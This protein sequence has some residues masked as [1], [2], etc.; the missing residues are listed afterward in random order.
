MPEICHSCGSNANTELAVYQTL[1]RVS[2]DCKPVPA[3]GQLLSCNECGAIS[4][5]ATSEFLADIGRIYA[6]YDVYYQGGGMEQIV[7]DRQSGQP[8][9]RSTLLADRLTT[10][11]PMK[12][13]GRAIDIGCGNGVFLSALSQRL[14]GWQFFGLELDD[15]WLPQLQKIPGFKD[16]IVADVMAF[17]GTFDVISMIHALEHFTD[18]VAVLK[19]IRTRLSDDGLLF[20]EIPNV[21]EN[22]FDLLIADHVTHNTPAS[23]SRMLRKAGFA[24]QIL[25]TNWVSKEMSIVATPASGTPTH[26]HD[27][28]STANDKTLAAR[29][30][31][32]LAACLDSARRASEHKPFGLFGTS[33]AATWLA[34]DLKDRIDFFVDEDESRQ[35]GNFFGHPII[36]PAK[37]ADGAT[38]F[39][40]LAPAI[41]SVVSARLDQNKVTVLL[42][43]NT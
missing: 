16:L 33:I 25:E 24:I 32:W 27:D 30:L 38:V 18:P 23:L 43:D 40:G 11:F 9:R 22:P 42:P 41:A 6:D 15:R 34:G 21:A 13:H 26:D 19:S 7:F 36:A 2:S 29:H 8:M 20:I 28:A 4:K 12:K 31:D 3:G 14:K 5:P 17:E 10:A 1:P 39:V 35:G 37:I